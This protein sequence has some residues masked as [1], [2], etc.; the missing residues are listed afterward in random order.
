ME[1]LF[2]KLSLLVPPIKQ[3][4]SGARG[5][6]SLALKDT[7]KVGG[8]AFIFDPINMLIERLAWA[9]FQLNY[10]ILQQKPQVDVEGFKALAAKVMAEPDPELSLEEVEKL[11][12]RKIGKGGGGWMHAMAV[13]CHDGRASMDR[14]PV[15]QPPPHHSINK[16]QQAPSSPPPPTG[17]TWPAPYSRGRPRGGT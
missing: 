3:Y 10:P 16:T 11:F 2:E 13:A 5:V 17:P 6:Y 1:A 4:V 8:C 7:K 15:S 14:T 9:P 12:W